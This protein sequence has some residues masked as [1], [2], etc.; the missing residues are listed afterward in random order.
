[1]WLLTDL[2]AV[3]RGALNTRKAL[4]PRS[5]TATRY[6]TC[7]LPVTLHTARVA[8][9]TAHQE[10]QPYRHRRLTAAA[11]N[12]KARTL[13]TQSDGPA[14]QWDLLAGILPFLSL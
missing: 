8:A 12:H 5:R 7:N 13:A 4:P 6:T 9:V 1:M 14:G 2:V 11:T 10:N 3:S